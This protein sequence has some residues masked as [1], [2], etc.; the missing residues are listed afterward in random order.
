MQPLDAERQRLVSQ[1]VGIA[2]AVLKRLNVHG[3]GF[4]EAKAEAMLA[5]CEAASTYDEARGA[6]STWAWQ[7]VTWRLKTWMQRVNS[8]PVAHIDEG[9][10][11]ADTSE[12]VDERLHRLK[13]GR[14]FSGLLA[15]QRF[16]AFDLAEFFGVSRRTVVAYRGR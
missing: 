14:R 10:D 16:S 8:A 15:D 11:V 5:L 12:P 7:K 4:E 1:N 3:A 9:F 13:S 6:F 2:F